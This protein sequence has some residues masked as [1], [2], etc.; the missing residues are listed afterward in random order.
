MITDDP[1]AQYEIAVNQAV[2][3][4]NQK[5]AIYRSLINAKSND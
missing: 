3:T 1:I 2:N 5:L 4:T